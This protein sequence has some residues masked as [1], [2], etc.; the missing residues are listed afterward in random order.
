MEAA[1][2]RKAGREKKER[3]TAT[4]LGRSKSPKGEKRMFEKLK[5]RPRDSKMILK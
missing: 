5:T 4:R 3:I 1:L 2:K